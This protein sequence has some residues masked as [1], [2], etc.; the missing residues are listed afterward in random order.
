MP[1]AKDFF[2]TFSRL[3]ISNNPWVLIDGLMDFIVRVKGENPAEFFS[4]DV[5]IEELYTEIEENLNLHIG[6]ESTL[7]RVRAF[8]SFTQLIFIFSA[9]IN[10]IQNGPV[11]RPHSSL[12]KHLTQNDMIATFNWDTLMDRALKNESEWNTDNGYGF[13]PKSI[14]RNEWLAPNDIESKAPLLIKLHGSVNWLSSHPMSP[15]NDVILTQESAPDT[16]WIYETTKHPYPCFAGRYTEGYEDF[17]YGYYPPNI[18]DD[19]GRKADEGR[20]IIRAKMKLPWMPEGTA[21]DK[22]LVSIPLIIPPVKKKI[23]MG[24]A[25][26]SI[27]YGKAPK[28]ELRRRSI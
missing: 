22:G 27:T 13:R 21:S 1:I 26:C 28:V 16:V 25:C 17:S 20:V 15:K 8:K 3:E 14:Y 23:T 24:L 7:D 12:A 19:R 10:S 4:R 18:L 2:S 6:E 5:D 9:T 11:S